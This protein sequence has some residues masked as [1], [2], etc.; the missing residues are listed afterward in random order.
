M[1]PPT[2]DTDDILA[3]LQRAYDQVKPDEPHTL[4]A[5]DRLVDDLELDSLDLID[6]VSILEDEFDPDV[7]DQVID[8]AAEIETV[9]QLVDRFATASAD[10]G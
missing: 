4:A 10:A 2:S 7:V 6:V 8:S 9:G 1:T 5:G 3:K